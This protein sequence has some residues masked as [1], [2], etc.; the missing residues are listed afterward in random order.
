MFLVYEKLWLS[1]KVMEE[2]FGTTP[3]KKN[4]TLYL[5]N[6]FVEGELSEDATSKEFLQVQIEGGR[7]V[8]LS[9]IFHSLGA[10]FAFWDALI[11]YTDNNFG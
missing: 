10:I 5:G 3:P 6:V 4:I 9:K 2:L 8:K 1:Q 11:S 7:Q